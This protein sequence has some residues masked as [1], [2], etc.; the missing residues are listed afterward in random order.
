[1]R[2]REISN[3]RRRVTK[4]TDGKLADYSS[5]RTATGIVIPE[6]RRVLLDR[7]RKDDEVTKHR[8]A[9]IYPSEMA[10]NDWCPRATY[11]RM[12]TGDVKATK[13]SFTLENVFNEGNMIHN[14]WQNWMSQT[15]KLWGD[16][17]CT[18][19]AEYVKDSV[20]PEPYFSGSCVGTGWVKLESTNGIPNGIKEYSHDWRYKEV[21]LRSTSL[22]IS[23]HAD[24]A[25]I[26]HDV[27]VELKSLGVGSL[28]FE[29]PQLLKNHTHE[30]KSTGKKIL[31]VDGIWRD[32]HRPLS[33]HVRQGNVYLWMCR[34]LGLPFD[35]ISIVYEFKS[36]Q[37]AKEF[38]VPYSADIMDPMLEKAQE[39]VYC[40]DKLG[41]PPDWYAGKGGCTQCRP[42]ERSSEPAPEWTI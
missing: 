12:T 1:M 11:Y 21:T 29:A 36:N 38:L 18:R 42:Y 10:K 27:L 20:R 3:G 16:W 37:Q 13:S 32:F 7:V 25:L 2:K 8:A 39:I 17:R 15:G 14:K 31:D 6:V 22:P 19:C 26:E 4:S 40:V 35:K 9:K 5:L 30:S 28:R 24:G 23:G 41:M 34:E 33:S